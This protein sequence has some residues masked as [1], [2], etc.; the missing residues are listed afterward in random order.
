MA[1][2]TKPSTLTIACCPVIT[3][4]Q[5]ERLAD[6][7]PRIDV[8]WQADLYAPQRY[9]GDYTGDPAWRRPP[10]LQARYEAMCDSANAL[11]GL[12]DFR[13]SGLLRCVEAN[14]NLIWVHTMAAGGGA[15]VRTAGLAPADL[16][17]LIITTSAGVHALPLSEFALYGVLA[18][19]KRL[20]QMQAQQRAH[21]WPP[22]TPSRHIAE[23]TIVVVGV[24]GIGRLV[25][26]RF[27]ALGAHVIGVNRSVK[28]VPGVEMHQDA[29]LA[30]VAARAD[31]IV[32]CLP[33]AIGTERLISAD[34]LAAAKPGVIVVSLGRGSCIDED[35]MIEHLRSGHISFAAL[36]VFEHEPLAPESPLWDMPNVLISP[37]TMALSARESDRIIDIVIENAVALLDGRPMRNLMNKQLFY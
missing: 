35:A 25:A 22:R 20:P 34:V 9:E 28:D 24:G 16:E 17:R 32:N 7:D 1:P 2:E 30:A 36:D 14:R 12:P 19:A 4:Q 37:H 8:L 21:T 27:T 18:G 29:D 26:E 6:A 23:M 3:Q 33:S 11:F 5:A 31:A 15:Q 13:S 10:A